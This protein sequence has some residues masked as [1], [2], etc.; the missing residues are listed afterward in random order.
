MK[1]LKQ[2]NVWIEVHR[3]FHN[4]HLNILRVLGTENWVQLSQLCPSLSSLRSPKPFQFS[5]VVN[6]HY[7]ICLHK[8]RAI[9]MVHFSLLVLQV[10]YF[11]FFFS[12]SLRT[13]QNRAI[14]VIWSWSQKSTPWYPWVCGSKETAMEVPRKLRAQSVLFCTCWIHFSVTPAQL[15]LRI[16]TCQQTPSFYCIM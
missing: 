8:A 3:S 4:F 5:E 2:R 1:K 16:S 14:C 12:H 6:S 9:N 13:H 11:T 7:T 15:L 10:W